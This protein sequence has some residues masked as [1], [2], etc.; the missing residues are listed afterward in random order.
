MK[1][2]IGVYEVRISRINC[3]YTKY[4]RFTI[5][6]ESDINLVYNTIKNDNTI[7]SI[8]IRHSY[9]KKW[10]LIEADIYINDLKKI[11]KKHQSRLIRD[12]KKHL[13]IK[14]ENEAINKLVEI[15]S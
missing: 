2:I 13:E 1:E 6:K 5:E 3:D 12:R 9:N 14:K 11:I 4:D 15:F 8:N 10:K 7:L